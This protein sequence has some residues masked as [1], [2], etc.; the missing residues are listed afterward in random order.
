M[1]MM[2]KNTIL[3]LWFILSISK[4][5]NILILQ[6]VLGFVCEADY[7]LVAKAI[8]DRVTTI[9]R[10][11]EK[12]RRQAEEAQRRRQEEVIEEEPESTVE[13][14]PSVSSPPPPKP[15]TETPTSTTTQAPPT[16]TVS[17]PVT[18]PANESIDS[19]FNAS[20]A[21]ESEEPDADQRQ[22]F[23]IQHTYSY[24]SA[25]CEFMCLYLIREQSSVPQTFTKIHTNSLIGSIF[26]AAS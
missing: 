20:F 26:Q 3:S 8:R 9:K 4:W 2:L 11:R 16:V 18:F 7:K 17:G 21:N 1:C 15:P 24:S 22:Y 19:G 10:Q 14:E 13:I 23:N 25:T 6:V 12:L 5:L